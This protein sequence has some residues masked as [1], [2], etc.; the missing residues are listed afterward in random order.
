VDRA[1]C[2]GINQIFFHTSTCQPADYG[3]PGIVYNA[4]TH[5]NPRVTWWEQ[6]GGPWIFYINRCQSLL[7]S[8]LFAADVLYYNGDGAPNL[9]RPKHVPVGLGKGYDYDVCN[10]E[11]LLTR[12]SVKDGGAVLA[13][14][15]ADPLKFAVL[16]KEVW[17]IVFT[18]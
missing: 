2:E 12:L 18:T 15:L 16:Q 5:V 10:E 6:A 7:Q 11:V 9:I 14:E 8:G 13:V 4:G 1:F 17:R 3:N